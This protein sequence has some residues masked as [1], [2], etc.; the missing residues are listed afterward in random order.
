MRGRGKSLGRRCI[1][2]T[3]EPAV[4][5]SGYA[6][7]EPCPNLE[8]LPVS[9][10]QRDINL[11]RT[12]V[13]LYPAQVRDCSCIKVTELRMQVAHSDHEVAIFVFI[14]SIFDYV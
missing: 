9:H 5:G 3:G 13:N 2:V 6:I 4:D 1:V 8:D 11:C 14:H 12:K 10:K 7:G